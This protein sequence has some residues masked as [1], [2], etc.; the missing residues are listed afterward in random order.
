LASMM[1]DER[2]D[3]ALA[4]A[5]KAVRLSPRDHAVTLA[6]HVCAMCAFLEE[7]DEEAV[8]WEHKSIEHP[9]GPQ[10]YRLLGAAL[11]HLGRLDEAREAIDEA[12]R[13]APNFTLT[14]LRAGNSPQLVNRLLE[15]WRKAGWRPPP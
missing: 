7:R 4:L 8:E 5:Q 10:S 6:L 13:L 11:G 3:E 2:P 9:A 1:S 14:S 12:M 15:G